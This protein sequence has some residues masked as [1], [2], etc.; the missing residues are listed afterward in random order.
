MSPY[1][2]MAEKYAVH[3]Q[4]RSFEWYVEW[5]ARHGFV[6][7]TPD[8]FIMGRRA[9][10][11]SLENGGADAHLY[12]AEVADTWYIHAMAGDMSRAWSVLPY[13]LP[14]LAWERLLDGKRDL[15]FYEFDKV[16]RHSNIDE[17]RSPLLAV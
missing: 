8:F 9:Y 4:E 2:Q 13:P 1:E 7:A 12:S 11:W 15:R 10:K 14:W 6:F 5:H 17:T 16:C 3:P